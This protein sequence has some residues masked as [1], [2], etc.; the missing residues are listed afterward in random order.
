[1]FRVKEGGAVDLPCLARGHPLP[2]YTWY[3]VSALTG[4]QEKLTASPTLFP[5]HS[6][7]SIVGARAHDSG[8]YVCMVTNMVNSYTVE[9]VLEVTS[10]LSVHVF[11][12]QQVTD[13][14]AVAV[15]NCTVDGFPVVN[16]YW[17]K[18]G[19]ILLPSSRINPATGS[20]TI[21]NVGVD[22]KG[23]N[24]NNKFLSFFGYSSL[25]S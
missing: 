25:D 6:V 17:L 1:M 24:N 18:D 7:L 22:D 20:L 12:V 3:K 9:H 10:P 11:P 14:G 13:S 23:N 19:K 8:R 21:K 15:F 16:V 5:R 2:V 4:Q